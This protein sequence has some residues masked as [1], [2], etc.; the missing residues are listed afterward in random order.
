MIRQK[1]QPGKSAII[2]GN[3]DGIGLNLTKKLLEDNWQIAGI[4]RSEN[5]IEEKGYKHIIADVQNSEY[6]DILNSV[7]DNTGKIDLCAYCVGIGELLNYSDMQAERKIIDV[8][9]LA[10]V[11]TMSVVIP[12]MLKNGNGHFIGLS[13]VADTLISAEAPSYHASKAG[14]SNYLEG[15]ALALKP[16]GIYVT[17]IRFGFVDTKMAK[18]DVKPFMM[19]VERATDHILKCIDKKP[20]RYTAPKIVIP[21]VKFRNFMLRRK[22]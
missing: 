1:N 19:S 16:R 14:L 18:G 10:A 5:Q 4:S 12:A 17:N 7:I 13:S 21:L 11:R 8:N 3:S 15:M 22:L 6:L 9:F 2:I 20:A